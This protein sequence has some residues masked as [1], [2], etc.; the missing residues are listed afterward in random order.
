MKGNNITLKEMAIL[1]ILFT[2]I[3]PSISLQF[4]NFIANNSMQIKSILVH[5]INSTY[6]MFDKIQL[7]I[8]IATKQAKVVFQSPY[9]DAFPTKTL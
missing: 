2:A 4:K 5:T 3:R 6:S 1:C 9:D 8:K 7:T